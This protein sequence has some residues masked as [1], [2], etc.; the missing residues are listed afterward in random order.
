MP[1]ELKPTWWE[2]ETGEIWRVKLATP[3]LED[4]LDDL[5]VSLGKLID[6]RNLNPS[7]LI[8]AL[9][10]FHRRSATERGLN[11]EQFFTE[12]CTPKCL[13]AATKALG[14]AFVADFPTLA[15]QFGLTEDE[16]AGP[17]DDGGPEPDTLTRAD[18][19]R[20]SGSGETLSRPQPLPESPPEND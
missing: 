17:L 15:D 6:W 11:R 8:K 19:Q 2:D 10:F 14:A 20:L 4:A 16:V 7:L 1:K 5:G 18:L 13:S 12:R 9:W 3:D